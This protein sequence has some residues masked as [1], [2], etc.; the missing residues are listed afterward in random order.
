MLAQGTRQLGN[1]LKP[2]MKKCSQI[3]TNRDII[4]SIW[5]LIKS[6]IFTNN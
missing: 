2:P 4:V 3:F 1:N 5:V 6:Q